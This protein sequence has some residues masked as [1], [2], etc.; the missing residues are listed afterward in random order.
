[1][2]GASFL[3]LLVD[4]DQG[5]DPE[6]KRLGKGLLSAT[7]RH[8]LEAREETDCTLHEKVPSAAIDFDSVTK[9]AIYSSLEYEPQKI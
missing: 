3:L 8:Q 1:M 5:G 2:N 6:C 4:A 9:P 7:R